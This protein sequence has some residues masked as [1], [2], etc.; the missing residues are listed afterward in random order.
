MKLGF[1]KVNNNNSPSVTSVSPNTPPA[2]ASGQPNLKNIRLEAEY[3]MIKE[4]LKQVNYNKTK[5]AKILNIDRKTLYN[6]MNAYNIL[7]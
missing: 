7:G 4:V 1:S 2:E 5:A 6:K 3:E